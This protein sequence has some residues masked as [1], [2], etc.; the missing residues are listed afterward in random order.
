MENQRRSGSLF[1]LWRL[2]WFGKEYSARCKE[3]A[4]IYK[5]VDILP[6]KKYNLRKEDYINCEKVR[7][8]ADEDV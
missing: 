6:N 4:A 5:S 8:Y 2:Y 3:N 7:R 1:Y